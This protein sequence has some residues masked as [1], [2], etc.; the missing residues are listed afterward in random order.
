MGRYNAHIHTAFCGQ[1]QGGQY[2][3]VYDQ[4]R[5]IDVYIVF[6]TVYDL[7]IDMFPNIFFV[8]G[9]VCIGLN[10]SLRPDITGFLPPGGKAFI[11]FIHMGAELPHL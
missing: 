1:T 8:H 11:R 10:I 7:E 6:G 9:A 5:R 3:V 2:A 4:V